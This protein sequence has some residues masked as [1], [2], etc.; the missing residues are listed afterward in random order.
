MRKRLFCLLLAA[1]TLLLCACAGESAPEAYQT[2]H[3]HVYG[4]SYDVAPAD[5]G[6]VT[7]QVRYCKICHQEQ[8]HPKQ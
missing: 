8:I 3:A 7:Q 5:G 6:A 1:L 4:A 2:D